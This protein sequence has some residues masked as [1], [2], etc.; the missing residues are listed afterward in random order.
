MRTTLNI[1]DDVFFEAKNR[2]NDEK[3]SIGSVLSELV[4]R[5]LQTPEIAVAKQQSRSAVDAKLLALGVVPY[6]SPNGK[7]VSQDLV[8]K[9]KEELD[10]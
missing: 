2:A 6:Y 1:E 4:R 3:R 5:A 7:A 8:N 10:I 9:L